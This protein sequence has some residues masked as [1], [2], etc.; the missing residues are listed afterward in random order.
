MKSLFVYV[1]DDLY[2]RFKIQVIKDGTTIKEATLTLLKL[3]VE[4]GKNDENDRGT[5]AEEEAKKKI[6]DADK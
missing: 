3:Y 2:G 1:P 5:K 4:E 6:L